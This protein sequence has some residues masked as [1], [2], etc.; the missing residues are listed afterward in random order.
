MFDRNFESIVMPCLNSLRLE[1]FHVSAHPA[2]R[3]LCSKWQMIVM[4]STQTH[5][6]R[7]MHA[8]TMYEIGGKQSQIPPPASQPPV[9]RGF[10]RSRFKFS[11]SDSGIST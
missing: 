6:G 2:L 11:T 10:S 5:E 8:G 1:G 4:K 3:S 9:P 7:M